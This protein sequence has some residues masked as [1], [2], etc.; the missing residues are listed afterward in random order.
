MVLDNSSYRW[1]GNAKFPSFRSYPMGNTPF[2]ISTRCT[3]HNYYSVVFFFG[4]GSF[5]L[6]NCFW[7]SSFSTSLSPLACALS[8][9][10]GSTFLKYLKSAVIISTGMCFRKTRTM[11][12]HFI[13]ICNTRLSIFRATC[14]L[15]RLLFSES[16]SISTTRRKDGW[17]KLCGL[18]KYYKI[19]LLS[20]FPAI[21]T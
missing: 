17:G 3:C 6:C 18:W 11:K 9:T 19:C 21:E 7:T 10:V 2:G 16:S 13:S 5:T 8:E 4:C 20:Y 14:A 15:Q 12:E 1:L